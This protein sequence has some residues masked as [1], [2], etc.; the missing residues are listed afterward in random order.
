VQGSRCVLVL[1]HTMRSDDTWHRRNDNATAIA[2][3]LL[4]S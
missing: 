1:Q 2:A 3:L 4:S